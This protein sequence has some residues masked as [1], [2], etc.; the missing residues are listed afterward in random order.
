MLYT[1]SL[2]RARL[3][4]VKQSTIRPSS[5]RMA[6]PHQVVCLA[7]AILAS[8]RPHMVPCGQMVHTMRHSMQHWPGTLTAGMR[9]C[10]SAA[11]VADWRIHP[12]VPHEWYWWQ[13]CGP[14]TRQVV[15]Q[16]AS[17]E[18]TSMCLMSAAREGDTRRNVEGSALSLLRPERLACGAGGWLSK[19][20][21]YVGGVCACAS[22]WRS[23]TS[24][25][26]YHTAAAGPSN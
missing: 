4:F 6:I 11:Q 20:R 10:H 16:R 1:C 18:K 23:G 22:L 25:G 17:S 24:C 3:N 2:Q 8:R 14:A 7:S 26:V 21:S 12:S 13:P 19:G 9:R 15:S 5:E